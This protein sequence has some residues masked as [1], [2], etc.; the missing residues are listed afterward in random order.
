MAGAI[1]SVAGVLARLHEMSEELRIVRETAGRKYTIGKWSPLS[2]GIEESA[3]VSVGLAVRFPRDGAP[4]AEPRFVLSTTTG[5]IPP[6]EGTLTTPMLRRL[7]ELR[8]AFDR[9]V[10]DG[11][12]MPPGDA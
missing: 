3:V 4:S 12:P 1:V 9:W 7:L 2:D 11:V 5:Q 6:I 10:S 8:E